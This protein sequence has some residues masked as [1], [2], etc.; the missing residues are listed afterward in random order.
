[1]KIIQFLV[2][3]ALVVN[4]VSIFLLGLGLYAMFAINREAFPNVSLDRIQVE[5]IYPGAS[6]KEVE[7]LVVTPIEQQ[8][9]LLGGI[10][11]MISMSFPG[12]GR[13]TLELDPD[14]GNRDRIANEVTLAVNKARLP[15]DLPNDPVVT[16]VDGS[17]FP[18]MRLAI[19]APLG[20]LELKRL[21]DKIKDDL[22]TVP[23]VAQVMVL[24]D[25][26]A[27]I[28]VVVKPERMAQ[29]RISTGEI[30]RA[31]RGWNL[32][33]PGGDIDTKEGQAVVRVVGEFRSAKDA[34]KLV[35]RANERGDLLRLGDVADVQETLVEPQTLHGVG[36]K[37]GFSLMVL[38]KSDADIINTVNSVRDYIL[39]VPDR[40]GDVSV[41]PFQDFSRFAR[42]RLGVLTNNGIVGLVL[43]FVSLLLFLR[44]S[45]ALTTT[46][47]LPIIFLSGL[48]ILYASGVTLNMISMMG[49][50]M[51][52]GMLVD[53]A[54]IVGENI[55]YHMEQG[56]H[57]ED[58]AVRGAVD[59]LG[60]VTTTILTTVAAFIPMMFMSGLIGKFIIAIPIV[61]IT[62]LLLSWLQ[63]FL[64]LPSHVAFVTN[65]DKHPPERAWLLALDRMYTWVLTK[66]VAHR[67]ITVFLSFAC[68]VA[69]LMLA[70]TLP[71]QLFPP[72]GVEEYVVR[73]TAP[74]GTSLQ[75][76]HSYLRQI[77]A[78]IK[79]NID[80]TFLE[81]TVIKSGDV[82]IDQGD[83]LTMRGSRYGQLRAIYT[84]AIGRPDHDALLE[85][86]RLA[87][88]II[89]KYPKLEINFTEIRPGPPL[90]RA[91]EAEISSY[92]NKASEAAAQRLMDFLQTIPGVAGI[93]SGLKRG[94]NEL[95][96]SLNRKLATYA[97]IDLATASRHIRAASGGLVVST[98]R[99]GTEELDVTIRYPDG[100][101]DQLGQLKRILIPNNRDGLVPLYKIARF[102]QKPG[103]T[104]IRHKEGIRIVNVVADIDSD[105]I[106]SI[107]LNK[108]V[109]TEQAQWLGDLTDKVSVNYGGEEEQNKESLISLVV[110]FSF[111]LIG[112]FFILAIQ[113]N[114]MTYPVI[115]MLAIPFGA[116]G[117]VI[118]FYMHDMFWKPMPLSFMS[119]L[120]MVALTGVVVNSALILL[121][122]IQRSV[123]SGIEPHE[124]IVLAGR[125]R[126]RAVLLTATTTVVG[127]LPT[128]YGWGGMDPFVSP[129]ALALS[130]GLVF[131]TA[132]TLVSIPAVLA[133]GY[134]IKH[135]F[136]GRKTRSATATTPG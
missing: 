51:V 93:D 19:S 87:K 77:D 62:L 39:T 98:V 105:K 112:I 59:L 79:A 20:D 132:V 100:K 33:V 60:P 75:K 49:F 129:M 5:A 90:G 54:I 28:R 126:L 46:L 133:A 53:D 96:V 91:L 72:A 109:R 66:A 52:L 48:F 27:E 81:A 74:P 21:G 55:T 1:M 6:P 120:G 107:E 89:A 32:N 134:D 9:R 94:D 43:V 122:F 31:L 61:V 114:N 36:G 115:V 83:P 23:G 131:A 127:L 130:W 121:V 45:V 70:K 88:V 101:V 10:D 102:E 68:L 113:F 124:A 135:M 69:A 41:T 82:S 95:H 44:I 116:I 99:H 125:R 18:I 111:A 30:E 22:L 108:K 58:A 42:M 34:E 65:P 4:L 56:M 123:Q 136:T 50:I 29:E 7:Q 11:K 128:A 14:A 97:G 8:L 103:F 78:D 15:A 110:A 80:H 117:I 71:F 104:T 85:M 67:W 38:K 16:E 40:Y 76:M 73:V 63:S 119:M 92:D 47:G 12:S 13:I 26:K 24:G 84:P 57:P 106:T 37:P 86:H 25:R 64:I 3:R 2:R 118:S 35:L 17:V